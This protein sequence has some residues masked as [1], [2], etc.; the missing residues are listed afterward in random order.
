MKVSN[1]KLIGLVFVLLIIVTVIITTLLVQGNNAK[2][3]D[4][5]EYFTEPIEIITHLK[6]DETGGKLNHIRAIV[7]VGTG[8]SKTYEVLTQNQ[9]KLKEICI[10][11][12][13]E[14]T[15]KQVND[16]MKENILKNMLKVKIEENFNIET[17]GIYFQ[18]VLID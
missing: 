11:F 12:F 17:T 2:S 6:P 16:L 1:Y 9:S 13:N 14:L 4:L 3:I 8:G 15:E 18:E 10:N 7:V 5:E